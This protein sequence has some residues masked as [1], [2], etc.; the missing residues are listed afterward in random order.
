MAVSIFTNVPSLNA[1]RN[2]SIT[3]NQ[4]NQS[5]QRLSS[6]L[7]INSAKDDAAG[8]AIAT[9]QTVQIQ[10]LTVAIRNANDGISVAQTAE[11]A[12]DEMVKSL[13]R[14]NDLALQAAS[15]NTDADRQ[16]L[17]EEVSQIVSELGR[18]VSQTRYNGQ[19]LLDGGF[20]ANFQVGTNVD[21]TIGINISDLSTGSLGVATS[22]DA[23]ADLDDD[24]LGDA[25]VLAYRN[26]TATDATLNDIALTAADGSGFAVGTD[27]KDI[28]NAIN[29]IS[30]ETGITAFGYGNNLIG[31]AATAAAATDSV[32]GEVVINGVAISTNGL[33]AVADVITAIN[34]ASDSTGVTAQL[35]TTEGYVALTNRTGEA[36]TANITGEAATMLGIGVQSVDAG[37]NGLIVLSGAV[38]ATAGFDSAATQLAITGDALGATSTVPL[39]NSTLND[40]NIDTVAGANLSLLIFQGAI[41]TINGD[42]ATLG[43]Q[44][45]R[46]ESTIR[47]LENVRENITA[48]RGRLVDADFAE[49]TAKLTRAQILQQAGIAMVAQANT[50]PQAAL[51][52]LQ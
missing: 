12:M 35:E 6:G 46:F 38:G 21:E 50:L 24:A 17:Q 41:D 23:I 27:S 5:I 28:I 13:V 48:A 40:A 15:Y 52:L 32:D 16:S 43:A 51:A 8:I 49:E 2:L 19:V 36:I 39:T 30:G 26:S 10:G 20:G 29:L 31:A 3:Q 44:L 42:R 11:G 25:A 47:N 18:I 34:N 14:A 22:Y 1:Q 33:S 7:R 9:R 37:D 45:N 4:L